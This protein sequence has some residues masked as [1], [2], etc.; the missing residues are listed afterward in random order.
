[1]LAEL[2]DQW[3]PISE[4]S[5]LHG[6]GDLNKYRYL[7]GQVEFLIQHLAMPPSEISV[8]DFGLGW[9]E[10]G[11]M[12]RAYGLKVSGSELSVERI[13]YARSIGFEMLS[14]AEI[15]QNLFHFINTEQVFEHLVSPR[16]ILQHLAKALHPNGVIR[17]SVPDACGM[18]KKLKALP[19]LAILPKG[20]LMPIAPLEHVNGF[21]Y[22]SLVTLG[23][24]A[25]LKPVRPSLRAM[26]N[27]SSGWFEIKQFAK[28]LLRP[29]ARH[30]Y[31][32]STVVYFSKI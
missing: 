27:G 29:L 11:N 28:N 4:K 24:Q 31:P 25:G 14:W 19:R 6:I 1:M 17:I 5:R 23:K 16:E 3:I 32:K 15:P 20:Y 22:K 21:T 26:Y 10:W 9:A 12:A 18:Q 13:N 2:Y 30:I 8:L 7:A